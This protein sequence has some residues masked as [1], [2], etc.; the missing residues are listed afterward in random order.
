MSGIQSENR[1]MHEQT[2]ISPRLMVVLVAV[3]AL[4]MFWVGSQAFAQTDGDAVF[5]HHAEHQHAQ[6]ATTA[7]ASTTPPNTN[8]T[9]ILPGNPLTA[10]GLATPFRLTATDP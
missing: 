1:D 3:V 7:G 4:A 6:A 8:C 9:L 5:L 2:G 10:Q